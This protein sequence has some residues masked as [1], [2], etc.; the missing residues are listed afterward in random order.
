MTGFRQHPVARIQLPSGLWIDSTGAFLYA[1][2]SDLGAPDVMNIYSV[3]LQTGVLTETA[4]SPL[5]GFTS[6]PPYFADPTGS[7][8]FG[9]GADQNTAIA[10]TVDPQTGYFME[11]A[12]SPFTI[13]QINGSL[14]FSIPPGQQGVSGPSISLSAT[15]FSFGSIQTGTSSAPQTITLTSNGGEA[16]GL[17]S[18]SLSGADPTQFQESDTCQVPAVLQ[19]TKFCSIS[20][21]FAPSASATGSQQAT[22]TITDNAPGNPQSVD[23]SGTGV[24]P[25][26]PAPAV[27]VL[28]DPV[29]FPTTAQGATS[30]PIPV[31]VTNSGNVTLHISSVV[32]GGNNPSDFSMT[33]LCNGPYAANA[34]C[35]ITLTFT[36]L[37]A[38]QRSAI[39]SITD[40][41]SNSPQSIQ[42]SGT[43]TS[44]PSN[45]PAVTF[46]TTN[47]SF[48]AITQGTSSSA[49][50]VTVTSSGGVPLHITSVVLGG[51]DSGDFSMTN[52]CTAAAYPVNSNCTISVS[53]A[54]LG[55]GARS[56]TVTLTDDAANSPQ[57]ISLGGFANSALTLGAAPSGSSSATISAGQTA[58]FNLQ[59][60]PGAGYSGSVS[61]TYS[62]A[63]T[64]ATI[65]GPSTLQISS[66]NSV[67]I[68]GNGSNERRNERKFSILFDTA[69]EA[70]LDSSLRA[71]LDRRGPTASLARIWR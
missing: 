18:I 44:A 27:T 66:G 48:A 33:N 52:G 12:N 4:S 26:P 13:P 51:A 45:S 41:A 47:L 8:D 6:V 64:G 58:Q 24:A 49:Q 2:I 16:L 34:S 59:I 32:L 63:P 21:T 65:Q 40:D 9:F 54:P 14:T 3:N 10:Y 53:F 15:S 60:T 56:A 28:P 42:V 46:S 38:G 20:I 11:T 71:R 29:S 5:P 37:A 7:F 23:L 57:V 19:P 68:H 43:A 25:P 35:T 17:N 55:S 31:A 50:S 70:L 1:A 22:L 39:L 69:L 67:A 61:F 62:G 30:S 36:P